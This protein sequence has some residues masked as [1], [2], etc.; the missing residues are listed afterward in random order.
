MQRRGG[1]SL[2]GSPFLGS[3]R[4]WGL[5]ARAA[6][7]PLCGLVAAGTVLASLWLIIL[8]W[9]REGGPEPSPSHILGVEVWEFPSGLVVRIPCFHCLGLGSIPGCGELRSHKPCSVAKRER[10][11][12][13]NNIITLSQGVSGVGVD[14]TKNPKLNRRILWVK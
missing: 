8:D 13:K 9:E 4:A 5:G 1:V 14:G 6:P 2:T 11:R 10:E 3:N 12:N 7:T